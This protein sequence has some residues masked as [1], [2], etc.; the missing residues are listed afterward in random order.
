MEVKKLDSLKYWNIKRHK[1]FKNFVII[2]C[3][4]MNKP[5]LSF[6]VKR[7]IYVEIKRI[8]EHI[9]PDVTHWVGYCKLTDPHIMRMWTKIGAQPFYISL[10]SNNLWFKK[11]LR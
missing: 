2:T 7:K 11:E 6:G 5:E 8:G 1:D 10:K 3:P 4:A 9:G